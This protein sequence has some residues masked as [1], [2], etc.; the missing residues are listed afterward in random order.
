MTQ[1]LLQWRFRHMVEIHPAQIKEYI[2]EAI[3]NEKAGKRIKINLKKELILPSALKNIFDENPQLFA[4]FKKF[5][6]FKQREF[7]DY[8]SEAKREPTRIKRL[9]KVLPLI[10]TGIGLNDKYR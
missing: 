8:V 9:E 1:G 7:A 5:T 6:P 10:E 2:N 4:A 3:A